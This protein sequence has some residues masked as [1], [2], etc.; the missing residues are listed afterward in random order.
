MLRWQGSVLRDRGQAPRAE[1]LYERSMRIAV[2][3]NYQAGQAH[4][5][6]CFG[7]L[8]HRRG[9]LDGAA[10]LYTKALDVAQIAGEERLAAM[11]QQNLGIIDDVRGHENAALEH[12]A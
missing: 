3:L 6:N 9:D 12:Y 5:H 11:V 4:A 8:A 7:T 10:R 1:A 2:S